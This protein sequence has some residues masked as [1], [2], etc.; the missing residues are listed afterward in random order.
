VESEGAATYC[1]HCYRSLWQGRSC[2]R[3]DCP[4]YA[5][6]YLRDHGERV[7]QNLAAWDGSVCLV[8][9]T[10]PGRDV[11]P[12]DRTKCWPGEHHCSGPRGCR[13]HWAAAASWNRDLTRRLAALLKL[14]RERTR[15][16]H[17]KRG[18][19]VVLGYVCEAQQ[20]GIFHPHV[21]LGYR[22]A[23]DRAALDTFRGAMKEARG[24]HGFGTGRKSFSAGLPDRFSP[25]DAARYVT[26]YL[27]PD[28][29]KTSFVP[30]LRAIELLAPRDPVTGR[31]KVLVRPV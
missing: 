15:R 26:K 23:A 4:S 16:R 8:T 5:A 17:G 30:L 29:A 18:Q 21:I 27:R 28:G 1:R 2:K 19:I 7:K 6:V 9:L 20:R 10:A 25:R 24:R 31:S 14:A 22:T 11:L 13:V 3:R 12:S